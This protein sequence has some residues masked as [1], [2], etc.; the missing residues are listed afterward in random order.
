M[1]HEDSP[2]RSPAETVVLIR[3]ECRT[4]AVY[5]FSFTD[6]GSAHAFLREQ[7]AKGLDLGLARAYWAVPAAIETDA[8]GFHLAPSDPPPI[9]R[10]TPAPQPAFTTATAA[11]IA[12]TEAPT[13]E[14]IVDPPPSIL[15]DDTL[16][17]TSS[18]EPPSPSSIEVDTAVVDE[19]DDGFDTE[20]SADTVDELASAV[21]EAPDAPSHRDLATA[22][23]PE[24]IGRD[25]E[26]ASPVIA[27]PDPEPVES[28]VTEAPLASD[29]TEAQSDQD[30]P[31]PGADPE[32]V[33][34]EAPEEFDDAVGA[35]QAL[36]STTLDLAAAS[37]EAPVEDLP[38][39][40]PTT[41][42]PS[43]VRPEPEVPVEQIDLEALVREA[44]KILKVRRWQDRDDPFE[45][46]D[47]PPGKF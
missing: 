15:M 32:D 38:M 6:M 13:P 33:Q 1:A 40:D 3:H 34:P 47:S 25:I 27:E 16:L 28:S 36:L 7:T 12:E 31:A 29:A 5:S 19:T 43:T 37:T 35:A 22:E 45:G 2:G 20:T 23:D 17:H 26:D 44:G 8:N 4:D 39:P 30:G 10:S 14:G 21:P 24:A 46:F 9:D 11:V 42:D 41:D 18:A